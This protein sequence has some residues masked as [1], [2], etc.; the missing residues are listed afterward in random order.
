MYDEI[1]GR[2]R[3]RCHG[4]AKYHFTI[5]S[6]SGGKQRWRERYIHV[7]STIRYIPFI[8]NSTHGSPCYLLN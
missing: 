8:I 1:K 7:C 6:I 4:D 5:S 2:G 3:R